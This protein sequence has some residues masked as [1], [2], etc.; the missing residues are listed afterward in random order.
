MT[1]PRPVSKAGCSDTACA[2]ERCPMT[3]SAQTPG[4]LFRT[5]C[6]HSLCLICGAWHYPSSE[7]RFLWQTCSASYQLNCTWQRKQING[8]CSQFSGDSPSI[9]SPESS[10]S[11]TVGGY[12]TSH[13]CT[14]V[15]MWTHTHRR[16]H[17]PVSRQMH[18]HAEMYT[19]TPTQSE[20]HMHA[21]PD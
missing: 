7:R 11:Y 6:P 19:C 3:P 13:V 18:T 20:G 1:P 8:L 9:A 15:H 14:G 10:S 16:A 4:V 5:P 12:I 21:H 2:L 17:T